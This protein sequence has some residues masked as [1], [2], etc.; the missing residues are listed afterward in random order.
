MSARTIAILA[1]VLAVVVAAGVVVGSHLGR[2]TETAPPAAAPPVISAVPSPTPSYN[3]DAGDA[4]DENHADGPPEVQEALWAP[5]VDN[6]ATNFTNTDGGAAKWRQR[7][8]GDPRQPYVTT[9][10]SEQ[11]ATVAMRRV[12]DGHYNSREILK[13]SSYD[14]AVKVDYREG[15]AMVL[16]LIADTDGHWQIYAYDK[17]ED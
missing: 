2:D 13:S 14:F 8:I 3:P 9:E 7:L 4:T 11:L 12:P 17:W 15:W 16:Y 10:V 6:F 1:A 5:A